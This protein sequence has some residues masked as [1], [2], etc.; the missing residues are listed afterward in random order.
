M[1]LSFVASVEAI[2]FHTTDAYSNLNITNE[3]HEINNISRVENEK[4]IL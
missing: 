1:R 4:V 2:E 3:K